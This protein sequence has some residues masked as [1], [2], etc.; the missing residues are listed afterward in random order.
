MLPWPVSTHRIQRNY[1]PDTIG[2]NLVAVEMIPTVRQVV[3]QE[4]C[5]LRRE[6]KYT[7]PESSNALE[8][9]ERRNVERDHYQEL[10]RYYPLARDQRAWTRP[11][12]LARGKHRCDQITSDIRLTCILLSGRGFG[13]H[14]SPTRIP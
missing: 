11:L 1:A 3:N 13:E 5:L 9:R 12:L 4:P 14:P 10:S 7:E 8:E 2:C 6:V